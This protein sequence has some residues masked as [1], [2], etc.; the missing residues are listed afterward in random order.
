MNSVFSD[1]RIIGFQS[2]HTHWIVYQYNFYGLD[3]PQIILS[4]Q[5]N[6]KLTLVFFQYLI[7]MDVG[8][9]TQIRKIYVV[10]KNNSN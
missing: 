8:Y 2:V 10:D 7:P 3:T 4:F 9:L 1:E 6:N 5:S